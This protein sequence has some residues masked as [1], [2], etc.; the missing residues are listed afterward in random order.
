MARWI[1]FGR[2]DKHSYKCQWCEKE[3]LSSWVF[4][5]HA[6]L[7]HVNKMWFEKTGIKTLEG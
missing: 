3:T 1:V 2:R 5:D 6:M 7:L 4:T